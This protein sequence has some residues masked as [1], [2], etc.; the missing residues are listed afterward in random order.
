MPSLPAVRPGLREGLE[1]N[2]DLLFAKVD[3]EAQQELAGAFQISSI[4]TLM[5]V[6]DQVAIFSQ[7][8]AL[9]EAA[10]TDLI[11]QAR[12]LDMDEVR[13]KIAAE[14]NGGAAGSPAEESGT[15]DA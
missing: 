14:R 5:I 6:R 3:T 8:G 4:P 12:A 7:P 2:P 11:A 10:L 15:P 13:T 1:A 9:P